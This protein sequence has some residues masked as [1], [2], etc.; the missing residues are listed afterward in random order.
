MREKL[1]GGPTHTHTKTGANRC[2]KYN[3]GTADTNYQNNPNNHKHDNYSPKKDNPVHKLDPEKL[4]IEPTNGYN[5]PTKNG[6][7]DVTTV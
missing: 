2:S 7:K 4:K 3:I 1:L 5:Q 6:V